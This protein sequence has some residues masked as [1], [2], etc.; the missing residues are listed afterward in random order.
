MD[1]MIK[2]LLWYDI[3]LDNIHHNFCG[4]KY[5]YVIYNLIFFK[6]FNHG[7]VILRDS[8]ENNKR[9]G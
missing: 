6:C 3:I 2:E 4:F 9:T 8:H 7:Y 1:V 5:G